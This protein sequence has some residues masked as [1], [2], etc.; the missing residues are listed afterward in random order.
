MR[1]GIVTTWFERGAAYVSRQYKELLCRCGHEVFIYA[2]G[3][4]RYAI[5]DPIWDRPEVTWGKE[6]DAIAVN[7][8]NKQDFLNWISDARLEAV[9]FNEQRWLPPVLW[10]REAGCRT[11]AYV[12]Y[13]TEETVPLFDVYDGLLCNT[14]RHY[15]VFSWHTGC[16]YLPWGTDTTLFR[17]QPGVSPT[18]RGP[19]FFHSAG[20]NPARKGTD[21]VIK[22]FSR[23]SGESS[24]VLHLQEGASF[25]IPETYSLV[26]D[27][28]AQGRL[29]L[30]VK[31]VPAPGLY[32]L[33]DIYVYP[34]H[35]EGI[36][37]TQAEALA[38]GL[39]LIVPDNPPMNEFISPESGIAV[40]VAKFWSRAD[41][42][43]WPQCQ[44]NL[45]AL[46]EAMQSFVDDF[47]SLEERKQA[48]RAYA[49]KHLDWFANASSLDGWL[50]TLLVKELP[51]EVRH[52]ICQEEV[53]SERIAYRHLRGFPLLWNILLFM[54]NWLRRHC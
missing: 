35:L 32:H 5:G 15:S 47:S 27:L 18:R 9:I 53:S 2:R 42:Y 21:F 1:I 26:E 14:K 10:A 24:L 7:A 44:V 12:D 54:R 50:E 49:E 29:Q 46:V 22:A 39:P 20:L 34:S 30:V 36:G 33:G 25:K 51:E 19:V 37:L 11:I 45:D 52:K 8:V 6:P 43:Y 16:F 28:A 31:D 17:P 38:C 4:E 48:A 23:L 13:Y 3:G 40:P 41:G